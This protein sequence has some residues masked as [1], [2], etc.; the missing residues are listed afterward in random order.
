[1][2][3]R[4]HDALSRRQAEPHVEAQFEELLRSVSL[5]QT[6]LAGEIPGE[7]PDGN[8]VTGGNP[9]R[10]TDLLLKCR[11]DLVTKLG[12]EEKIAQMTDKVGVRVDVG[13]SAT[14]PFE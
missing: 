12:A 5:V 3:D 7:R 8:D 6:V 14:V 11:D 13:T 4:P 1:L 2:F 10:I 9:L